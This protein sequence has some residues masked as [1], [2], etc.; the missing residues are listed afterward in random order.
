MRKWNLDRSCVPLLLQGKNQ[1]RNRTIAL[2][3]LFKQWVL[4]IRRGA[5]LN[6]V[7]FFPPQVADYFH[8]LFYI[9]CWATI[10]QKAKQNILTIISFSS[11]FRLKQFKK[12]FFFLTKWFIWNFVFRD[13]QAALPFTSWHEACSTLSDLFRQCFYC[14][15]GVPLTNCTMS[16]RKVTGHT[17]V[18]EAFLRQGEEHHRTLNVHHFP[19][20]TYKQS[21]WTTTRTRLPGQRSYLE[22]GLTLGRWHDTEGWWALSCFSSFDLHVGT[23]RTHVEERQIKSLGRDTWDKWGGCS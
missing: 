9:L 22:L 7:G 6:F 18:A 23:W 11:S 4:F 16:C 1:E 13:A 12:S 8:L 15:Q 14:Q 2:K 3:V 21:L 19:A 17:S 10:F 20:S 5:S